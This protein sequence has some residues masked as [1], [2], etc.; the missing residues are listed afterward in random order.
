[1]AQPERN[2]A[3]LAS[4][5]NFENFSASTKAV[6]QGIWI[7]NAQLAQKVTSGLHMGCELTYLDFQ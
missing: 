6:W 4:D 1:M 3:E 2:M 7:Y 5:Y